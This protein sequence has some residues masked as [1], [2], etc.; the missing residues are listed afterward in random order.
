M[1]E[2][3]VFVLYVIF[4]I[5]FGSYIMLA[6][7]KSFHRTGG[8]LCFPLLGGLVLGDLVTLAGVCTMLVYVRVLAQHLASTYQ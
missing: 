4:V 8:Y 3:S 7:L 5:R 2:R 1:F 6:F